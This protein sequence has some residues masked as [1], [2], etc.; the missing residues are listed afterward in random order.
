MSASVREAISR[1]PSSPERSAARTGARLRKTS[2]FDSSTRQTDRGAR[3]VRRRRQFLRVAVGRQADNFHPVG[4]VA[5]DLQRAFA[6][7]PGRAENNDAFTFHEQTGIFRI[8]QIR[9]I[10]IRGYSCWSCQ[11]STARERPV[12]DRN[13]EVG[14]VK[15]ILSMKVERAADSRKRRPESFHASAPFDDRFGKI[16]NDRGEAKKQP[17]DVASVKFRADKC[18]ASV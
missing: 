17:E 7:R 18:P 5:R 6:N 2:I 15:R 8:D 16:A 12:A 9:E 4:N 14:A 1:R 3:F 11:K 13:R 10:V